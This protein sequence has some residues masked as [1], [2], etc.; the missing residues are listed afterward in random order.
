MASGQRYLLAMRELASAM[1]QIRAATGDT[2]GLSAEVLNDVLRQ[3]YPAI[4]DD[5]TAARGGRYSQPHLVTSGYLSNVERGT[6][7]IITVPDWAR[8][9]GTDEQAAQAR[10]GQVRPWLVEAYDAAFGAD[11]FLIDMYTWT[12]ALQADYQQNPPRCTRDLPANVPAGEEYAYLSAG[13]TGLA[14]APDAVREVLHTHA[15]LY[16]AAGRGRSTR[17]SGHPARVT[18]W[19]T[20]TTAMR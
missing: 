10:A 20:R 9:N 18:R 5:P 11:G 12:I 14:D 4:D 13:L 6:N 1:R 16:E 7:A 19:V 17:R 8:R 15:E 2:H 3:L